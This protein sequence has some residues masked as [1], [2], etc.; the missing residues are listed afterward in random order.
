MPPMKSIRLSILSLVLFSGCGANGTD[1][2]D[3]GGAPAN[4]VA[5][6]HAEGECCGS[7]VEA[8]GGSCCSDKTEKAGECCAEGAPAEP[9]KTEPSKSTMPRHQ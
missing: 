6:K 2:I 3:D 1:T 8:P 5:P 4:V 9:V 7:A